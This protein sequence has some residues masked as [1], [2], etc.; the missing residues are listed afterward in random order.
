[1]SETG[2]KE[3]VSELTPGGGE[4][5]GQVEV[6][7]ASEEKHCRRRKETPTVL[8]QK[9]TEGVLQEAWWK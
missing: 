4:R 9:D 3:K 6:S 8:S 7:R 1:M 2:L 5:E